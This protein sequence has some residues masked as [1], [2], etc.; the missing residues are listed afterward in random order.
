[1]MVRQFTSIDPAPPD[2]APSD[3]SSSSDHDAFELIKSLQ[4]KLTSH[5]LSLFERYRAMFALRNIIGSHA[6][7]NIQKAAVNALAAGFEDDSELFKYVL[8]FPT[9]ML[10][11]R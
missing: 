2:V 3:S 4:Q 9:T 1:M 5:D 7:S 8:T 6:D 10:H 11:L